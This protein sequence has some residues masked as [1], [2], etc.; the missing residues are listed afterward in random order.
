MGFLIMQAFFGVPSCMLPEAFNNINYSFEHLMEVLANIFQMGFLVCMA[1]LHLLFL[2]TQL[3]VR[4]L[5]PLVLV[6]NVL[7]V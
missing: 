5:E 6:Y 3:L 4:L 7:V 2:L 1:A